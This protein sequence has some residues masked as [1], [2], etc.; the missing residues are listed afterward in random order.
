MEKICLVVQNL[1]IPLNLLHWSDHYLCTRVLSQ[2]PAIGQY[3][4]LPHSVHDILFCTF[5]SYRPAN[6]GRTILRQACPIVHI[7]QV[8]V[9]N[10]LLARKSKK[11]DNR[12]RVNPFNH[13][14]HR[15]HKIKSHKNALRMAIFALV[16]GRPSDCCVRCSDLHGAVCDL[17]LLC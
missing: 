11:H 2:F 13:Q 16:L 5:R 1:P 15:R 10:N 8:K 14:L 4:L 9:K 7:L 3:V 17:G 6:G 12:L